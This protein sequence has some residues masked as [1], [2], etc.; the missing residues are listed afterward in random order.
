MG[1]YCLPCI[2]LVSVLSSVV[3]SEE[4]KSMVQSVNRRLSGDIYNVFNSTV[5]FACS[6]GGNLTFLVSEKRCVNNEELFNGE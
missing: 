5:H 1:M 6:D 3:L 2:I 4:E